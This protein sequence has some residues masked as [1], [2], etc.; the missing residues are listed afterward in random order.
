[1]RAAL[2]VVLALAVV[3]GRELGLR[4]GPDPTALRARLAEVEAALE[5]ERATRAAER[6]VIDALRAQQLA[7]AAGDARAALPLAL[8]ARMALR[9]VEPVLDGPTFEA[10]RD[11]VFA[12]GERGGPSS[13]LITCIVAG[14]DALRAM[15]AAPDEAALDEGLLAALAVA[16]TMRVGER[17]V[18]RRNADALELR[19]RRI[20]ALRRMQR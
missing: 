5:T 8:E 9:E 16:G 3:L 1:M 6:R 10:L 14:N 20:H 19:A 2:L 11:W 13:Q 17:E 12:S 18:Y 4:E 7:E 15:L